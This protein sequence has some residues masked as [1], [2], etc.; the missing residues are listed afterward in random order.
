MPTEHF[1]AKVTDLQDGQMKEVALGDRTI[2]LVRTNG[3]FHAVGG[4]CTH[5]D[6]PLAKGV[7]CGDRVLCPWHL[8]V[9]NVAT[10]NLEEPPALDGLPRF[11]VRVQGDDVIVVLPDDVKWRRVLPMVAHDPAADGRTFVI[12]G[13]GAAGSAAAETLRQH[14]FKGRLVMITRE[15]HLPYDRPDLSKGYL[16]SAEHAFSPLLRSAKFYARYGIEVLTEREVVCVDASAKTVEFGDRSTLTY[17]KLLLAGGSRPRRLN[18]PGADLE[19][20]FV[21]RTLDDA[22]RIHAAVA[23][24]SRAVVV[25]ASF[26]GTEVAAHLNKRGLSVTMVAPETVPFERVFGSEIGRMFQTLHQSNGVRLEMEAQV[27]RFEG[28]GKVQ[29]VV[30]KDG[31]RIET[32]LVVVGVGATPDTEFVQGVERR[33]DG[34]I[35]VDR[36]LRAAEDLYA[37]GDIARF[38]DARTG[39]H[40][41]I[42]HW[43]VAQQ[44]GRTAARNMAG[45]P[46]AF[47]AVPVFWTNQHKLGLRYVGHAAEWDEVLFDGDPAAR[48][49]VA[50]Y[51]RGHRVLAAAGCDESVKMAAIHELMRAG[52]MPEPDELRAG[53]IDLLGRLRM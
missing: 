30:L 41:R 53:R 6:G 18:V 15:R 40:I 4:K 9:F 25:G 33:S 13:A 44:Q 29:R 20:V 2:L 37:A 48:K 49:F 27:A 42:E 21:L 52:R 35:L 8:A 22:D 17:D 32:D 7:L 45:H 46:T 51:I 39:E 43:R 50:Y 31:R 34:S 28:Q 36:Y 26:I 11:D 14:G 23:G 5:Y 38:I 47:D 12:V 10:G 24:A 19:G 16:S 1:V 3:Q